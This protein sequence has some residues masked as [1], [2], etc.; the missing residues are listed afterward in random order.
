MKKYLLL[1]LASVLAV[2]TFNVPLRCEKVFA[3]ET[4]SVRGA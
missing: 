3:V 1:C 2:T 4:Q